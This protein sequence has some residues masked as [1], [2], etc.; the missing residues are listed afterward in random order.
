MRMRLFPML[1][2]LSVLMGCGMESSPEEMTA[3]MDNLTKTLE[4]EDYHAET[5]ILERILFKKG[6][7]EQA[8][9]ESLAFGLH[10]LADKLA[11]RGGG[12]LPTLMAGELLVLAEF[13]GPDGNWNRG[14][15]RLEY[16]R[17]RNNLF[18]D[19]LWFRY[20]P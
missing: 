20:K 2:L 18:G 13:T 19:A 10:D 6:E 15:G 1:L 11:E 7:L 12:G 8:E 3:I 9:R 17:I 5:L 4:A 14:R 16:M